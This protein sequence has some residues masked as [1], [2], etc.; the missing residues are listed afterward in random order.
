M[1]NRLGRALAYLTEAW[2][3]ARADVQG[4]RLLFDASL[5]A[6]ARAG[7]YQTAETVDTD[8]ALRLAVTSAWVYSA[9]NLIANR[10]SARDALPEVKQ[11]VGD[12]L[13]DMG[14]H[15]FERL[16]QRPNSLMTG[17]YLLRYTAWWYGLLGNAYIFIATAAPGRGEPQELWPLPANMMRPLPETLRNSVLTGQPVVDY[18]YTVGGERQTLPGENVVH[19]RYPNPFDWWQGLSP[20]TA[21]LLP[22]QTD[23]AQARWVR[24]YF[25]KDNAVPTALATL[26]EGITETDFDVIVEQVKEQIA[27]GA[28]ILFTRSGDMTLQTLTHTLEQMQVIASRTFSRDEI[29]RVY[30]IPQGLISGGLSGDSRL[31]A[32]ISFSRN[33]VQP[34]CDYFADVWTEKIGP[35][36]GDDIVLVARD[37]VPQDRAL[38]VAEYTQYAQDRTINE[39]RAELELDEI[40]HPLAEIPVRLLQYIA[41]QYATLDGKE[42][43]AAAVES[44][45]GGDGGDDDPPGVGNI[46]GQVT[47][48]QE[49]AAQAARSIAIRAE[50]DRWER[51][52]LKE[53]KAGRN[54]AERPFN[55]DVIPDTLRDSV[56]ASLQGADA[57]T[58]KAVFD[59][60]M[61]HWT[62][63]SDPPPLW[64]PQERKAARSDVADALVVAAARIVAQGEADGVGAG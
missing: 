48:E 60:A 40:E 19:F 27:S 1:A 34:T 53:A 57:E 14:N 52:A 62:A 50:M 23:L 21:A 31:A 3:F 35:Y 47:P 45:G 16:L 9:L 44:T 32:E 46:A 64:I 26:P 5:A 8:A 59:G 25:R 33:T 38:D 28:R 24:D 63:G 29:D 20:L 55:S 2:R 30:G 42:K 43:P 58:V 11:R 51:V 15:E 17:S 54:P 6:M 13:E 49:A 4:K 39:N 18:E 12:E 7:Q 22:V 36:Y 61:Q 37:V 56:I 41:P 10:V